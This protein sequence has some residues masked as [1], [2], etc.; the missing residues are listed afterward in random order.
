MSG[1]RTARAAASVLGLAVWLSV[2][3]A[4]AASASGCSKGQE[5][6]VGTWTSAEQGETLEFTSD[7]ALVFTRA[8]G[9][10]ETLHWQAD[11]SNLAIGA[12]GGGTKTLGYSIDGGVLTLKYQGQEPAKYTKVEAAG[13]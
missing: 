3:L 1:G 8:S 9:K 4:L 12:P 6:L 11:D 10:V 5:S 7:G 13:G 2:A